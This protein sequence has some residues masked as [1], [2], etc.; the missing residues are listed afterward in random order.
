[1][2]ALV[3]LAVGLVLAACAVRADLPPEIV[4]DRTACSHCGMLISEPIYAA[5]YQ[6]SE[7]DARVFDD[8]GCLLTAARQ[9]APGDAARFWVHDAK[10][11]SW[12]DGRAAVFVQAS[13]LQ[14]PMG[15]GVIAFA[16]RADAEAAAAAHQG[17]IVPTLSALLAREG[18][19]Q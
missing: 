10:T 12:I 17:T 18:G 7:A 9:G 11:G 13:S 6:T 8:I 16:T 5:A 3:V 14:T 15:G 19:T 1:M 2:R 4:V